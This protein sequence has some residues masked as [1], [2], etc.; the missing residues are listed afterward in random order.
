MLNHG[1][2]ISQRG[3]TASAE[4]LRCAI[5]QVEDLALGRSC[6]PHGARRCG[7]VGD[8]TTQGKCASAL[9]RGG[10]ISQRGDTASVE[11]LR[12]AILQVEDL[13]LGRCCVSH[14]A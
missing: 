13:A 1:G 3:D 10:R 9:N 2:R 6:M 11:E 12:C 5:P 14:G 8:I 7:K 4:E